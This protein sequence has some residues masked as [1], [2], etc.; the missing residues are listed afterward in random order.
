MKYL[1]IFLNIF[2]LLNSKTINEDII[3]TFPDSYYYQ[4]ISDENGIF[5]LK[6]SYED[7]KDCFDSVDIEE[8]TNFHMEISGSKTYHSEC[9]LFKGE[10][11]YIFSICKFDGALQNDETIPINKSFDL[12]YKTYNVKLNF[13]I[14]N[15]HLSKVKYKIPFLYSAEQEIIVDGSKNKFNLE[16][17]YESYN[18]ELLAIFG[19]ELGFVVLENCQRSEKLLKCEK[20][21]E[22]LDKVSKT[23]N[24]FTLRYFNEIVRSGNLFCTGD[25]NINY[26]NIVK[27]NIF[28][29]IEK[30]VYSR[31]KRYD[32]LA[33]PTNITN[34]PQIKTEM[35]GFYLSKENS[36]VILLIM[37]KKMVCI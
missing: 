25:I 29:K 34:L 26:N 31:I 24:K 28:L 18:N 16:F 4:D 5:H 27:E 13:N 11:K 2:I 36:N 12:T 10:K 37:V 1:L 21:K 19:H 33:F 30:P 15:L 9:R 3:I 7:S 22:N 8:K 6:S 14:N 32:C 20:S 23:Q 35:F 17:K